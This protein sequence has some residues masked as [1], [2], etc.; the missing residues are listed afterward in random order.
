M[1]VVSRLLRVAALL[2]L[3]TASLAQ[4]RPPN[5]VLIVSDDQGWADFGFMGHPELQT[6][7]LDRLAAE[8]MVF[9]RG[10]V[11]SSLCRPSLLSL[12]T[13]LAPHR[14]GV[15]GNDPPRG[16]DRREME[17]FVSAVDTLPRLLGA[18]GYRSLQTGKWWEGSFANGGFT[19]GMTHGDPS[20]GGRHGDDGLTIGRRGMAPIAMFLD[21][22]GDA[23]FFLWYAPLL[24]H[25]PHDAAES[26]VARHRRDGRPEAVARYLAMCERFDATVA[27]LLAML[28]ERDLAEDTLV[29]F[30]VDNGW[31]QSPQPNRYAE[32]SKRSP[33]DGGVRTPIVLRWPGHVPT[34]RNDTVVSSLDIAPTVLAACGLDRPAGV[35]GADL[36]AIANGAVPARPGVF[37]EIYEHD[38]A[39]LDAPTASLLFRWTVQ[40]RDKLIVP[41]DPGS[42][43]ELY[44]VVADPYEA[45]DRAPREPARVAALR[46][47]LDA[48]WNPSARPSVLFLLTDDQR[49]DQL[50]SAGHPVLQTPNIDRIAAR[51]VRFTNAFVTTSIC[52]ASRATILTGLYETAHRF[53]FGTPPLDAAL[54]TYPAL[55][56][57]AGYRTG[58]VGKLGV[59]LAAPPNTLF[60]VFRPLSP[61][62]L[63][64]RPNS[65]EP[66]RHLTDRTAD[67]AIE[68]LRGAPR[69]APFCLSVSFNAPHAEDSNP[70]QYVPPP[71]LADRYA[72]APVPLPPLSEPEFFRNLPA[73]QQESL[74][75]VRWGWR[76]DTEDKRVTMTRRYWA[77]IAGVDRAVGRILDELESLGRLDS[78]IV[79]FASDNGYFLGERGFAGKW[80]IHEPSIRIPLIVAGPSVGTAVTDAHM[81]LNVDI[82]PTILDLCGV[83]VPESM[84]GRSLA[85]LL[86]GETP[87]DWR[88][89]MFYEHRFDHPQIPK[90]E[91]V[92]T[93]QFS[94]VRYYEQEP[95]Q[96]ELYDLDADPLE[97]HNL[98]GDSERAA[99]LERLRAE[100]TALRERYR[101]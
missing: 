26:L 85:P 12:I 59:K 29:A 38:V 98:A 7:N 14:H 60:D 39:D 42:A 15:T 54:P 37:G 88:T 8:G 35:D 82:A 28:D 55:L 33:Y 52:A 22:V 87:D 5:V 67:A 51:G 65:D 80:T 91:G 23:P 94:Y 71:D 32:R 10:Y 24:P 48:H 70:E 74:N 25:A 84:Q 95:I 101:R 41:A 63:R 31:I 13:G 17:R 49:F 93:L 92:R 45:E 36:V 18:R 16:T 56:R 62:Y 69:D 11:P 90:C 77:M 1:T 64:A 72:D 89:E 47:S 97:A 30:V 6:P 58:F 21:A 27:E 78:T 3:A 75:R 61:P 81:A 44:D 66:P 53:T 34:G 100:T 99:T 20:R 79:V 9:P 46:A 43:P 2:L 83:A 57:D 73:F 96:E 4:E 40:G 50:S 76:F 19:D 86:R 68:F